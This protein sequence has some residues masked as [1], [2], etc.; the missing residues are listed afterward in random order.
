MKEV[1]DQLRSFLNEQ[2][3]IAKKQLTTLG[4]GAIV[5]AESTGRIRAIED[6]LLKLEALEKEAQE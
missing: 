6:I 1:L 4:A 3:E 5:A 2:R